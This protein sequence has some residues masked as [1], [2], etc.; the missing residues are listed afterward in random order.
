MLKKTIGPWDRTSTSWYSYR[1]AKHIRLCA[2]ELYSWFD[3]DID[4]PFWIEVHDRP[5][6]NRVRFTRVYRACWN[7]FEFYLKR[8]NSSS[9]MVGFTDPTE[10]YIRR[11]LLSVCYLKFVQR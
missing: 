11:N 2:E 4:R 10:R 7:E 6:K 8:R 9:K 3:I 5:G 1:R